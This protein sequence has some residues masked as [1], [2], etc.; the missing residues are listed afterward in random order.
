MEAGQPCRDTE[1]RSCQIAG[2]RHQWPEPVRSAKTAKAGS[3]QRGGKVE[4]RQSVSLSWAPKTDPIAEP[5]AKALAAELRQ[6][7]SLR[8]AVETFT[9]FDA[10][11]RGRGARRS[12]CL[13]R[14][15]DISSSQ[16]PERRRTTRSRTRVQR[17]TSQRTATCRRHTRI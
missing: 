15:C 11:K 14:F 9:S 3:K 16:E 5:R 4:V 2:E 12:A 6:L 8:S 7:R 1:S 17:T 13:E 10:T